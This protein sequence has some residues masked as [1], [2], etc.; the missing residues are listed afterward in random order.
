MRSKRL[1]VKVFMEH[2]EG[3]DASKKGIRPEL[4]VVP[5]PVRNFFKKTTSESCFCIAI[6]SC[7]FLESKYSFL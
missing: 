6:R 2:V 3:L 4:V 5:K 7:T 1:S